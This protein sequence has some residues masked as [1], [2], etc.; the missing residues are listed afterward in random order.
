MPTAVT[1]IPSAPEAPQ[2]R[3]KRWTRCECALLDSVGLFDQERVELVGGE[4]ISKMGKKR[5]HGDAA[6][7][8]QEWL[9]QIFGGRY[10]NS[11]MPID[12]APEDNP[13]N[14]PVPD[15]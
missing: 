4:L 9:I 3:R 11:E 6:A 7:L 14:E 13:T 5:P 15:L 12:V 10:V 1:E 8:L 2:P